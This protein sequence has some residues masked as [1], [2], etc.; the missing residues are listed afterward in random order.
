M[1]MC[2]FMFMFVLLYQGGSTYV[3]RSVSVFK[4][5][6]CVLAKRP[7]AQSMRHCGGTLGDFLKIHTG[8]FSVTH[9]THTLH[10]HTLHTHTTPNIAPPSLPPPHKHHHHHDHHHHTHTLTHPDTPTHPHTPTH[11]THTHRT[12]DESCTGAE[13]SYSVVFRQGNMFC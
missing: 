11:R 3:S 5:S 9:H 2:M 1:K 13:L 10:T 8:F 12:G 6:Q 4:T 7:H